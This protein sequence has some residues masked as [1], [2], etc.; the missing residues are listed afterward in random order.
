VTASALRVEDLHSYYGSAHVLFGIGLEL[1]EGSSTALLG[2]NGAGKTTLLRSIAG[3]PEITKSG[4]IGFAGRRL[5][6][7]ETHRVARLGVQLVPE[8][9]RIFSSLSVREN[10]L[11]ARS[12]AAP[13]KRP[14]EEQQILE[15]LPALGALLDRPGDHLSGGQQQML[16]IARAMVANP[17][18]LLMDEPSA[19]LAPVILDQ[20]V[21]VIQGIQK[22]HPPTLLMAE[23]N[24]SFALKICTDVAVIEEGQIVF[25]GHREELQSDPEL[26]RI[27]LSV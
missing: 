10:L 5:E 24:A 2:R 19:G 21:E 27:Y 26:R 16:A 6:S 12:A 25:R 23:Q 9:R 11:L 20:L 14:L 1:E 4:R 8:D 15:I 13:G 3:A 17:D 22:E 18:L 7:L